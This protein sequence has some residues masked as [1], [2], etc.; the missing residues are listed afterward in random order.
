MRR[1]PHVRFGG[2]VEE[3]DRL[4]GRHC[5]LTRPLH[6]E[7][8]SDDPS[9]ATAEPRVRRARRERAG[10]EQLRGQATANPADAEQRADCEE[11]PD[12][13]LTGQAGDDR[14]G[15]PVDA[16]GNRE[17]GDELLRVLRRGAAARRERGP[18]GG[19]GPSESCAGNPRCPARVAGRRRPA[20]AT[21]WSSS[22]AVSS[23]SRLFND[24]IC[25]VLHCDGLDGLLNA[26]FPVQRGPI[27]RLGSPSHRVHRRIG[28]N[29][30]WRAAG[31]GCCR[32]DRSTTLE[33]RAGSGNGKV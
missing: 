28:A 2:R 16:P 1:E 31:V 13:E 10:D 15:H 26:T 8:R 29:K 3:T 6:G 30:T 4:N 5:A 11:Q 7:P 22:K 23:R 14:P 12:D 32:M 19:G 18:A 27:P 33:E 9:T 20:S 24:R 25:P 17:H 21:K